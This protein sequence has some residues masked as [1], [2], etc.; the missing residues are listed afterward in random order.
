MVKY[1]TSLGDA[2]IKK[3]YP[4]RETEQY[5]VF[6]H[7]REAKRSEW[8]CY[9]NSFADAKAHLI[10][11]ATSKMNA[12]IRGVNKHKQ[13]IDEISNLNEDD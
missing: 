3:V 7:R 1:K 10:Q 6:T 5:V 4:V 12:C 2:E 9:F 13:L 11:V 8:T